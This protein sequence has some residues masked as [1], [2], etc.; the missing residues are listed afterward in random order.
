MTPASRT[1]KLELRRGIVGYL[2]EV[3][4]FYRAVQRAPTLELASDVL[5]QL[6]HQAIA[7][8]STLHEYTG[9]FAAMLPEHVRT[10]PECEALTERTAVVREWL[11]GQLR[12]FEA[13]EDDATYGNCVAHFCGAVA[14]QLTLCHGIAVAERGLAELADMAD[15]GEASETEESTDQEDY[16]SDSESAEAT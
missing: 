4:S 6:L 7:D 5:A 9:K 13:A 12:D 1:S 2:G 8:A 14:S 15:D 16:S 10:S 11:V 3:L